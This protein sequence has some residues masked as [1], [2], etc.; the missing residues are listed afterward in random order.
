MASGTGNWSVVGKTKKG[1]APPLTKNQK[2][3]FVD[4]MPRIESQGKLNESERT[5]SS[6]ILTHHHA[7]RFV[8]A[9]RFVVLEC[10]L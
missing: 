6:L 7:G 2:K 10:V 5:S 4:N 8:K 1:S 9:V 3:N